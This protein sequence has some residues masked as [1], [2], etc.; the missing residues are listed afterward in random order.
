MLHSGFLTDCV[1]VARKCCQHAA[2]SPA[3]ITMAVA[4][5]CAGVHRVQRVPA[6][7]NAGRIHTSTASIAIMPEVDE[8]MVELDPKD[9]QVRLRNLAHSRDPCILSA[10]RPGLV[11][12]KWTTRTNVGL[13]RT[14]DDCKRVQVKAAR[15]SGAGGQNV[16]KVETAIDLIHL[17]TG[18]RCVP[19]HACYCRAALVF[20]WGAPSVAI[21]VIRSCIQALYGSCPC[22]LPTYASQSVIA[23][24]AGLV[25]LPWVKTIEDT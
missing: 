6:T 21:R 11:P 15:A 19:A 17:P 3:A 18:I 16:N 12:N 7:E 14:L 13:W 10:Y 25:L 24:A 23:R 4:V 5:C 2:A 1:T 9:L 20:V 8:V 22:L